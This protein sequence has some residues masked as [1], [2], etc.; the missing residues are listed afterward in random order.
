MKPQEKP[1]KE[2][3]LED[4]TE[5]QRMWLEHYM[6]HF[7]AA[8]AARQAGYSVKYSAQIGQENYIKLYSLIKERCE[9]RI[10]NLQI[11]AA[12]TIHQAEKIAFSSVI[13]FVVV[14]KKKGKKVYKYKPLEDVDSSIIERVYLNEEGELQGYKFKDPIKALELLGR[15]AGIHKNVSEISGKDG[16]P[17]NIKF[18]LDAWKQRVKDRLIND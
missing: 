13:D 9:E 15:Y 14:T 12:R 7:N 10:K 11:E 16:D 8:K 4:L 1:T 17:I 3:K 5:K 18:D 6:I 2:I